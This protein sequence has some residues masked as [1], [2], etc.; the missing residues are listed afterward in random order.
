MIQKIYI[1]LFLMLGCCQTISAKTSY[2]IK[3]EITSSST[4]LFADSLRKSRFYQTKAKSGDGV[5][6]ILRRY[7]LLDSPCNLERFYEINGL[8]RN[9][10]LSKG[11]SYYLPILLYSYNGRSIRSTVGIDDWDLAI[12]IQKYNRELMD[13]GLRNSDYIDNEI[14]WVPYH[15][16]YCSEETRST[17]EENPSSMETRIFPIFGKE[18]EKVPLR[19]ESLKGKVYYI[20]SGHGGPD[21]G[22]VGKIGKNQVCEDEYAYDVA[23]RL[24]REL[25]MRGGTAY[26]ITRDV[27]DGIRSGK[28]FKH[29]AD[30]IV[31]GN[32]KI[33]FSQKA[34][35]FQRSDIV[36]E[37]YDRNLK[38]G[39]K[40]QRL[41]AIH[42]DSRSKRE[43]TDV[44]FYY[45]PEEESSKRIAKNIQKTFEKK[46]KKYQKNRGYRGTVTP[47]DLHM[48]REPQCN[49][50]YVE[51]GNIANSFDQQRF[52]LASNRQLLAEWLMEGL[53]K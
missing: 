18:Y 25:V 28:I 47:R 20:V 8:S 7:H 49:A 46:Y 21:P 31:W 24:A 53:I 10:S 43:Q 37:L 17:S 13:S 6:S 48:L 33:P 15:E 3:E 1:A 51:L 45:Y 39:I 27:N 12:R 4:S 50:V 19:D 44:F 2:I 38:I 40:D 11:R 9:G 41:I 30:E 42:V 5:Y 22:A 35:L 23:L 36:N 52:L 29:D 14:L 26:M 32:Y 34:R 16:M